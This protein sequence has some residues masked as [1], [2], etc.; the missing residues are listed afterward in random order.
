MSK[1]CK[2]ITQ[3][4]DLEGLTVLKVYSYGSKLYLKLSHPNQPDTVFLATFE[5][6]MAWDVDYLSMCDF[7]PS[8]DVLVEFDLLSKEQYE[9]LQEEQER[10]YQEERLANQKA[11]Y[12][13][14]KKELGYV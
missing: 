9:K 1:H 7:A 3:L 5:G 13:E 10:I 14:L 2:V 6:G 8:D 11:L 12:E 4:E